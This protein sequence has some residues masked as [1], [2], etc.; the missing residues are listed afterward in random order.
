[1]ANPMG[2]CPRCGR[3]VTSG[4]LGCDCLPEH[5]DDDWLLTTLR[6]LLN[7]PDATPDAVV[8]AVRKGREK[9]WSA[10]Q[11]NAV[12]ACLAVVQEAREEGETDLRQVRDR[13]IALDPLPAV[14]S[15]I[16]GEGEG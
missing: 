5:A 11:A 15:A 12:A 16:A 7:L 13:F 2:P 6:S 8:E 14:L 9:A 4:A 3:M 1:M 10:G